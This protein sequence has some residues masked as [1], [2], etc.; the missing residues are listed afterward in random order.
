MEGSVGERIGTAFVVVLGF[1]VGLSLGR[2][3]LGLI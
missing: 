3:I 1:S 2:M